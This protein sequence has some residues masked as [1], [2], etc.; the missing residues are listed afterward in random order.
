MKSIFQEASSLGSAIEKAWEA[1]GS[2]EGFEVKILKAGERNFFG[3]C[4]VPY[5]VRVTAQHHKGGAGELEARGDAKSKELGTD[6]DVSNGNHALGRNKNKDLGSVNSERKSSFHNRAKGGLGNHRSDRYERNTSRV[7]SETNLS[8]FGSSVEKT[9]LETEGDVDV[10]TEDTSILATRFLHN[11][12]EILGLANFSLQTA[13]E[14]NSLRINITCPVA[15]DFLEKSFFICIA[16]LLVQMVKKN[17]GQVTK[18]LRI[19]I[20]LA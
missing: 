1:M 9:P 16:P 7:A 3:F 5:A 10:W 18:G 4:K 8:A 2:P 20:E 12:L 11:I 13:S 19:I 14:G 17:T 15:A 6:S